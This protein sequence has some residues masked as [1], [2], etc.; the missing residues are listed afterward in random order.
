[1]K[2]GLRW[3]VCLLALLSDEEGFLVRLWALLVVRT[4][5]GDFDWVLVG[6][7]GCSYLNVQ[8]FV[9]HKRHLMIFR[10]VPALPALVL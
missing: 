6:F 1:M 3:F 5:K 10:H 9:R 8:F 7:V 4:M 2:G